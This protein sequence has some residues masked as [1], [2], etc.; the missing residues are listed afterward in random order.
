M[1]RE[2][3]VNVACW[4]IIGVVSVLWSLAWMGVW[5]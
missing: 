5:F 4:T 1:N 3:I 2:L